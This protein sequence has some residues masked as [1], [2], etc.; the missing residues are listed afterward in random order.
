MS[1]RILTQTAWHN[2]LEPLPSPSLSRDDSLTNLEIAVTP[3]LIAV[4]VMRGSDPS[5]FVC[6]DEPMDKS[7]NRSD[8]TLPQWPPF[9]N[10]PGTNVRQDHDVLPVPHPF[11]HKEHKSE[12]DRRI[13]ELKHGY[14]Q[15]LK[16]KDVRIGELRKEKDTQIEELKRER[17][18]RLEELM[19][20]RDSRIED[21]KGERDARIE[22]V[23]KD[24]DERIE[25]LKREKD[26]RIE[27][28]KRDREVAVKN[29]EEQLERSR[30]EVLQ[31][32][33]ENNRL[34]DEITRL[35]VQLGRGGC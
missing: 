13:E 18:A 2:H 4:G 1:Y 29:M 27:E 7:S 17:D 34:K 33:E 28:V 21:I 3:L 31:L 30:R 8:R 20:E 23:K 22:E 35:K 6:A 24:R 16:E 26:A 15:L 11:P 5:P 12:C 32:R 9:A 10:G 14:E 25:E 19:K